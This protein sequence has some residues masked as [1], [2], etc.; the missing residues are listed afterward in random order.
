MT[1]QPT[2]SV[3]ILGSTLPGLVAADELAR[4]GYRVTLLEHPAWGSNRLS[5]AYLLGCHHHAWTLLRSLPPGEPSYHDHTLPLEFRLPGGPIVSYRPSSLPGSLHWI[6]GLLRFRGLSWQDRWQLLSYLERVW[7]QEESVPST[8][9][10]RTAD[11]WLASIG[12]SQAARD[13]IWAPLTRFLTGNGLTELSAAT[14]AQAVARPFLSQS[15]AARLTLLGGSIRDRLMT[16]LREALTQAGVIVLPQQD[17]PHVH[18]ERNAVGHVR[19]CDGSTLQATWYLT[20]L[21]HRHLLTLIPDRLLTRYAYF[22][23]LA[24]LQTRH[25]L[26]VEIGGLRKGQAPRLLLLSGTSFDRLSIAPTDPE[27]SAYRFAATVDDSFAAHTDQDL[28]RLATQDLRS[29]FP[30]IPDTDLPLLAVQRNE[31]AVL[32]LKPGTAMSRPIQRSPVQNVLVAG[33]WT[34]TG[35][36]DNIESA[37][38]SARQCVAIITGSVG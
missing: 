36:P 21:P 11:A 10:Q 19:L 33:G 3:L 38:V 16:P 14:F 30:A 24:E 23:H 1:R 13:A 7:E 5:A 17:L 4:G 26:T 2:E 34:D 20:A 28:Y 27:H 8:L 29:I 12:Q 22:S 31:Q 32:S 35:W 25:E 15:N 37:V 18:F 9:E 6:A